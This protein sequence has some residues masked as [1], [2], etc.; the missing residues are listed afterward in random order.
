MWCDEPVPILRFPTRNEPADRANRSIAVLHLSG[1]H[2]GSPRSTR[3][4]SASL[5]DEREDGLAQP[6]ICCYDHLVPVT[7]QPDNVGC[8]RP[9]LSFRSAEVS[10]HCTVF[11]VDRRRD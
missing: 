9:E 3:R 6:P 5:S 11:S 10:S 2:C 8:C 4:S 7:A 1:R